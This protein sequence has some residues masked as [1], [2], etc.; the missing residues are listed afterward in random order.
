[1]ELLNVEEGLVPELLQASS[2][3]AAGGRAGEGGGG[4]PPGLRAGSTALVPAGRAP[5]TALPAAA[6]GHLGA[7][8]ATGAA[9]AQQLR[10]RTQICFNFTSGRCFRADCRFLHVGPGARMAPQAPP[11]FPGMPTR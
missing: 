7:Q 9:L 5:A 2:G 6:A 3:N 11:P 1:M 10:G 4:A 8:P